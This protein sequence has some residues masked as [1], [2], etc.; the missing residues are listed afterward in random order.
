MLF[1]NNSKPSVPK[2]SQKSPF[3]FTKSD[4]LK[5]GICSAMTC[6]ATYP[7]DTAL[8]TIQAGSPVKF[9]EVL[10]YKGFP[11]SLLNFSFSRMIGFEIVSQVKRYNPDLSPI[12][13]SLLGSFIGGAIKPFFYLPS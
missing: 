5:A 9:S 12:N 6:A 1:P 11:V 3:L 4:G 10:K 13:S 7:L 8:R 2:S